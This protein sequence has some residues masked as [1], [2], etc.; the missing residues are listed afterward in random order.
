MKPKRDGSRIAIDY[1]KVRVLAF[2][3]P[4]NDELA[5]GLGISRATLYRR[6]QDDEQKHRPS[7]K[8]SKSG[9]KTIIQT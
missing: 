5:F 1:E 2:L 7:T 9:S 3:N 6:L 8:P 4:S